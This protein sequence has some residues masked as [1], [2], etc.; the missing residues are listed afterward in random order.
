MSAG[1]L[2]ARRATLRWRVMPAVLTS[3]AAGLG[4]VLPAPIAAADSAQL[5]RSSAA[6]P[7]GSARPVT[8]YVTNE[9]SG[10]V[11][12]IAAATNTAGPPITA[13]S[14]PENIA[15]TP[16]A[17]TL[18]VT[19]G[20]YYVNGS[21]SYGTTVTPIA[22]ATNT[23]GPP[24]TVGIEP[25]GLA[26]TPDGKT[27]YIA[28]YG[29]GTVTPIATATNT[30]GPPITVG[31][32]PLD[33]A[34]TPDGKTA[35]VANADDGT[36]TPIATATNIPG[37][38]ITVGS[39]PENIAIT[40]DGK[41]AYVANDESGTV[42]PIATATN[43]A[44]PP[45][46]VGLDPLDIAITPDGKTAYVANDGSGT[47]TPIAT[48]TNTAAPPISTGTDP[49]KIAIT[50]DGKTAYV[51]NQFSGT[52]TPIAT[53]TNTA[54]PPIIV[55][56]DPTAIAITPDG[57]TAYVANL[58]S[59]TVTPISTATNTPGPPITVGSYPYAIALATTAQRPAFTSGAAATAA[60]GAAFTFTVTTT[61]DPTPRITRTGRLP[62]GVR[63]SDN[64]DGTATIVGTPAKAA[65]GL[66]PLTLTAKNKNGTATQTFSLTVT[67]SP[68]IGKIRTIMVRVGAA[69]SR[70]VR[71]VGYPLPAL[72]ESGPLPG[73]LSFTD[74]GNGTAVIAGTPAA[75]SGSRYPITITATNTSG[76]A[77]SHFTI[78]VSL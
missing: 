66:Y 43:T 39:F 23:A 28:N 52:V 75:G 30:A 32:G 13:G 51:T 60:F 20:T 35:Y 57:K 8:A 41:T 64:R 33:I 9:F 69:L 74:N 38:S 68:A 59:G 5:G 16:D 67:R 44:D 29:S 17:K 53:A 27:V 19:N 25:Y 54:G 56:K 55:G 77:T 61:G 40:P 45:I 22:A 47:V 49:E 14:Y 18:Y 26:I 72:A 42:T 7:Q 70:T 62:S 4:S 3:L 37:P 78:V 73:G 48:A 2:A 46:T 6:S 34:I 63:F 11:T 1:T 21:Y 10:T 65:A 15:I 71:A 12:P 50:P 58:D 31:F 76:T 24:I 36:V